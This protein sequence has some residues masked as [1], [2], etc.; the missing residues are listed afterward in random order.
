MVPLILV[1][2]TPDQI[3]RAK[4]ANGQRKRITHALLCGPYGQLFGTEKQCRKYFTVWNPAPGKFRAIFPHVFSKAI[5]TDTHEIVDFTSTDDLV[6]IL[7][8]VEDEAEDA[9]RASIPTYEQAEPSG[10]LTMIFVLLSATIPFLAK[11]KG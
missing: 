4:E 8:E 2:L 3:A 6:S 5:E 10:C 9:A 11:L 1:A 7:I